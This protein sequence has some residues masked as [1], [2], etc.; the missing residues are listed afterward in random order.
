[1]VPDSLTRRSTHV[2]PHLGR[3]IRR[4]GAKSGH[5]SDLVPPV[6]GRRFAGQGANLSLFISA[7]KRGSRKLPMHGEQSSCPDRRRAQNCELRA[8]RKQ[9]QRDQLRQGEGIAGNLGRWDRAGQ[10]RVVSAHNVRSDIPRS[11]WTRPSWCSRTIPEQD[12]IA[13]VEVQS[14]S[15]TSYSAR[16]AAMPTAML[17]RRETSGV[18]FGSSVTSNGVNQPI[19]AFSSEI[20]VGS[21]IQLVTANMW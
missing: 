14:V 8:R 2:Q 4:S 7:M 12:D 6:P 16:C 11:Q 18:R 3:K 15:L 17:A 13:V 5:A 21:P 9:R 19:L 10:A 1:L 20:F